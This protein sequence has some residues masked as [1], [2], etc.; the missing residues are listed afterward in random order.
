MI[1]YDKVFDEKGVQVFGDIPGE[2]YVW[3]TRKENRDRKLTVW[4]SK[5]GL[6]EPIQDYLYK[7]PLQE[8]TE[9][10]VP[11]IPVVAGVVL[12]IV[13]EAT[14]LIPEGKVTGLKFLA[15]YG[16]F[17]KNSEKYSYEFT[18]LPEPYVLMRPVKIKPE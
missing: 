18:A 12:D 13:G 6:E 2:V 14:V 15:Q 3:C 16:G 7:W 17:S 8:M 9:I 1:E 4:K 11:L 10:A 5:T